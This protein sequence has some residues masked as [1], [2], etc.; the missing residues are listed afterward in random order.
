MRTLLSLALL[1]ALAAF[2]STPASAQ[3]Q[4]SPRIDQLGS[5]N[6]LRLVQ[7]DSKAKKKTKK[8]DGGQQDGQQGGGTPGR[9]D[10]Y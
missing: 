2:T 6:A 3:R 1:A 8:K 9:K 4:I 5:D 7:S 10:S